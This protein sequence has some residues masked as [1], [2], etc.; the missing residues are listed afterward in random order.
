LEIE[1]MDGN[2]V[3]TGKERWEVARCTVEG[4]VVNG[5]KYVGN[6]SGLVYFALNVAEYL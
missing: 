3:R 4:Q 5:H 6:N 2:K 1:L